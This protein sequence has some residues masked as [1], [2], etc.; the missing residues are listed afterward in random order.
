MLEI[1]SEISFNAYLPIV[2][3]NIVINF[4]LKTKIR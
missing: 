1:V 3:K 4:I 2:I